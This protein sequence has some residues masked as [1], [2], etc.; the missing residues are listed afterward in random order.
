M[1]NAGPNTNGSQVSD[2]RFTKRRASKWPII[3]THSSSSQLLWPHGWMANTLF[4]EKLLT[5][6]TSSRK[7]SLLDQNR[8]CQKPRS[9]SRHR[10]SFH[11]HHSIKKRVLRRVL[12]TS[13]G[14]SSFFWGMH[15]LWTYHRRT[16]VTLALDSPSFIIAAH[17]HEWAPHAFRRS[18]KLIDHFYFYFPSSFVRMLL[19]KSFHL[20]APRIQSPSLKIIKYKEHN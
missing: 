14:A 6:W 2:D 17:V 3:T 19:G 5:E 16:L 12:F 18:P 9:P 11:E 15:I 10:G 1:A 7:S 20:Q 13:N 4:L 8:E